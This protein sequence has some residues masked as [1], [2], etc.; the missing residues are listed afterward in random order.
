MGRQLTLLRTSQANDVIMQAHR[1]AHVKL[2]SAQWQ[3][4]TCCRWHNTHAHQQSYT[5]VQ[6]RAYTRSYRTARTISNNALAVA[7]IQRDDRAVELS[8]AYISHHAS[9]WREEGVH[10]GI[11]ITSYPVSQRASSRLRCLWR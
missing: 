8:T 6:L 1:C 3:F 4:T 7:G 2:S 5:G 9:E 10:A 11:P